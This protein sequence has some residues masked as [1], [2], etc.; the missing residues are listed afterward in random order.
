MV[1][2]ATNMSLTSKREYLAKI[3]GRYQ[4]AG[5]AHKT[6]ILD[7]FCLNCAYHRKAALR[8][9]GRPQ[10]GALKKKTGPKPTYDPDRFGPLLKVFWLAS[11]QLCSKRLVAALPQWL[12]HYEALHRPLAPS[13]RQKLLAISP[14][15]ID[16]LLRPVRVRHPRRG[17]ATTK[18]GSLLRHR[19]PTRGG[20]PNT[21]TPGHVEADTVAH[22]GDTTA[23]DFVYSLTFTDLFSGWT[24]NRA[25]WNKGTQGIL[26]QLK[27]LE[28][29]A[30]FALKSFHADNGSEFLNWALY[31]HLSG[32]PRKV[33]FTRSRAYRK[34]DNAHCEQKNYT[35]VRQLFGHQRL[36]HPELVA[37]MNELYGQEWSQYQN[38]FR[39]T[40]KLLSRDKRG[41]KTVRRYAPLATPYQRLLT[42]RAITPAVKER[43][44]A[45]HA[46]LNP[47][48][49]KKA[50][51][52][53]LQKFFT[54]LGNL[55]R[56][57]TKP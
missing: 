5:R 6:R 19:I 56:E 52:E 36:E 47:F 26:D 7:E 57:S 15:Q 40:F 1:T 31:E 16:R 27:D 28:A 9:L 8:L 38:H 14:A 30:P 29:R 45:E 43:L 10:R 41:S 23:G 46:R 12:P 53:K 24:E 49:L 18:P 25:V 20:P 51:E 34:N 4:R 11:D 48:V 54:L 37:L 22:C 13:L 44:R 50:I 3:L 55:D 32:R 2:Q 39:P 17:L 33:A 42:S 35:F 21:S